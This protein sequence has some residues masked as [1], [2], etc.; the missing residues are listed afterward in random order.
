MNKEFIL[1]LLKR[2]KNGDLTEKE[3]RLLNSYIDLFQNE[4]DGLS[5]LNQEEKSELRNRI[6]SKIQNRLSA[7]EKPVSKVRKINSIYI[8]LAAAVFA[9]IIV[10]TVFY[11]NLLS[12]KPVE[13]SV[14]N[15]TVHKIKQQKNISSVVHENANRVIFLPDGSSVILSP[16]SKL[17]YPSSFD[18]SKKRE[19]FLD[20]QAFFDV[21][22]NSSRPFI[23]HTGKLETIV[24]G[25]AFNIKS[26]PGEKEI[27]VTVKRGK[28]KVQDDHKILGTITPNQQITYNKEKVSSTLNIVNNDSYLEWKDRDLFI[29]N[30]T[31]SEAAKLLEDQFKVKIIITD[32]SIMEQRFTAT[33]P[34]NETLDQDLKSISVFNE[35]TYTYNDDKTEII[36]S[37]Q[38]P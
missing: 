22:H 32:S 31:L 18:G 27:I 36:I 17:N 28:V 3:R 35:V 6:I 24:L 4:P 33:F 2:S 14:A 1:D 9:G 25:T 16:G 8:K 19:V 34:R 20:G 26:I 21:K 15:K 37:N 5:D 7:V 30:L 12:K 29:D 13:N 11:Y 23:V 38:K 10:S